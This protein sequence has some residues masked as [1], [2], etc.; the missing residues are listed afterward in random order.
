MV[1]IKLWYGNSNPRLFFRGKKKRKTR[2]G[3]GLSLLCVR[4]VNCRL[5]Y[6]VDE[7]FEDW[8]SFHTSWR[9]LEV[10]IFGVKSH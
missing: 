3:F 5:G 7:V 6:R 1:W 4:V 2:G 8:G 10:G 9:V